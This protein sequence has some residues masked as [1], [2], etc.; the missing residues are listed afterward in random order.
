M[1]K[2]FTSTIN[3]LSALCLTFWAISFAS[4]KTEE[5][6]PNKDKPR[7]ATEQSVHPKAILPQGI[8]PIEQNVGKSYAKK[9]DF[10]TQ[11]MLE[12]ALKGGYHHNTQVVVKDQMMDIN[13]NLSNAVTEAR[14]DARG[15]F[16]YLDSK[17]DGGYKES[18][19]YDDLVVLPVGLRKQIGNTTADVGILKAAFFSDHAELTVFVRLKTKVTDP[20]ATIKE[21]ELFFGADR[22]SFTKAGGIKEFDAVLL[23]DVILNM[24]KWTVIVKGGLDMSTGTIDK[25]TTTYA[26][27]DCGKFREAQLVAEV[28]FPRDVLIPLGAA[29]T[30]TPSTTGRVTAGFTATVTD[31]LAD[32]YANISFG[33][34]AFA[35]ADYQKVGFIVNN[36]VIDM[37]DKR[38]SSV[39]N[40]STLPPYYGTIDERWQ[41][42]FMQNLS[43]IL[44]SEFQEN[45]KPADRISISAYNLLFDR[46]GV[47]GKFEIIKPRTNPILSIGKGNAGTWAFSLERF[48]ITIA[49]NSPV[50]G[51]FK[52][53][54][55]LPLAPNISDDGV[56]ENNALVYTG[57][58]KQKGAFNIDVAI[59]KPIKF[60]VWNANVILEKGTSVSLKSTVNPITGT[61][62]FLPEATLN[63]SMG[64]YTS[65]SGGNETTNE[66]API[67][68][69]GIL[70]NNLV[71][72]TVAPFVHPKG[73]FGYENTSQE[74]GNFPVALKRVKV[75]GINEDN[76]QSG[77]LLL[78]IK[79]QVSLMSGAF[80]GAAGFCIPMT[81]DLTNGAHFKLLPNEFVLKE[82]EVNGTVG[83]FT[84]DGK[85]RLYD[86]GTKKGF[87]GKLGLKVENPSIDVCAAAEFGYQKVGQYRYWSVE[88][89]AGVSAAQIYLVPGI[90]KISSISAAVYHNMAAEASMGADQGWGCVDEGRT[91]APPVIYKP[92]NTIDLGFKGVLGLEAT[93]KELFAG[94]AGLEMVITKDRGIDH[95]GIFGEGVFGGIKLPG[96]VGSF[97][98]EKYGKIVDKQNEIAKSVGLDDSKLYK[99]AVNQFESK[100]GAG[101]G[102][103]GSIRG[104]FGMMYNPGLKTFTG[105]AEVFV[106]L[107]GG[108]I[109]GIGEN[110]SAGKINILISPDKW[111]IHVGN[112]RSRS[113]RLG[114]QTNL[115]VLKASTTAYFMVGHDIPDLPCPLPAVA[116]AFGINCSLPGES[117]G[118]GYDP[119]DPIIRTGKGFAMGADLEFEAKINV[120]V[121]SAR[122]KAGG[123]FDILAKTYDVP[124]KTC[125]TDF[126]MGNNHFYTSG[127]FYAYLDA[128]ACL[129]PLCA[130]GSAYALLRIGAP[131]PIGITGDVK[132]NLNAFGIDVGANYSVDI[133][134]TCALR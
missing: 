36:A 99:K 108:T 1:K 21:R 27:I 22:V 80:G 39:M 14:N 33:N 120:F 44:P 19:S 55:Q 114:L 46:A 45:G 117:G 75:L 112:S 128:E 12:E 87:K 56:E 107:F 78:D 64:I 126:G 88:A 93:S 49:K 9:A 111:Y 6:L 96:G 79:I 66:N 81:Y 30:F 72:N 10:E 109:K 122:I 25:A 47:S 104:T 54:I 102:L 76:N 4:A 65:I 51:D 127:Q 17:A 31:G 63:G 35:I 84:L 97:I 53:E 41:G 116:E 68:F 58:F 106:N 110:G 92:N 15:V 69:K 101:G 123:G 24:G 100:P 40:P 133:G 98:D 119:K 2:G 43:I 129:G 32:L 89:R 118:K 82:L 90:V 74:M 71:L 86:D 95:V 132:L 37:S 70:F 28:V 18:V 61:N 125:S 60:A 48:S 130:G 57:T 11:L 59:D 115:G 103:T 85:V 7:K 134:N 16:Q 121:A 91:A 26:T 23:G 29:P 42:F 34:K 94:F 113:T 124:Y 38:N 67:K 50:E 5:D 62:Y 131:N 105:N 8:L 83:G 77:K 73:P 3:W 52:G 13:E 20:N